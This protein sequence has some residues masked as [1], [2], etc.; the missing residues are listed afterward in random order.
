MKLTLHR[1]RTSF[2]IV[3]FLLFGQFVFGQVPPSNLSGQELKTWLKTNYWD[4]KHTALGYDNARMRLYN[5]VDN[6]NGIITCPYSG[7]QVSSPYGGTTTYPAPIN[8]EHTIPQSF[9][10]EANPMV[11]DLH[12]LF[13]THETVNGVR[14]NYPFAEIPDNVTTKWMYLSNSQTTIPTSNID[15]YSEFNGSQFEP[16]EDDKGNVARA[17]FY[18]YTMYPAQAGDMSKVGDINTFY[19]WHLSDPVDAK[20]IERNGQI[21]TYQGDRNPYIDY[22]DAVARAWGFTAPVNTAPSTPTLAIASN[23]SAITLTW[24][25]VASETG[26]KLYKSTT[27]SSFTLLT[28]LTANTIN[29]SD[30]SVVAGQNYYYYITAYNDYGTSPVSS[31]VVKQLE[32]DGGGGTGTIS[33]LIISEYIEGSSNNK[34]LEIANFTGNSV[35]LSSYTIRKQSNGAGAWGTQLALSG[36]LANGDVYVVVNASASATMKAV[37]DLST[38]VDALTFNGN[39][40]IGLFKNTT[41]IDIVGVFSAVSNFALDVTLMPG[42]RAAAGAADGH[43]VR[44]VHGFPDRTFQAAAFHRDAGRHVPGTWPVLRDQHR[45]DQHRRCFLHCGF[46]TAHSDLGRRLDLD[47]CGDRH[48]RAAG[49]GLHRALHAVRPRG[50]RGWRQ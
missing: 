26:Y 21:E 49:R 37:A 5:Y 1:K 12:H 44:R 16:R 36:T 46:A 24:S 31:T 11:S 33:D 42:A 48:R 13:P 30:A 3:L 15:L 50:L 14:S 20:E 22:P 8:C 7:Y 47:Q 41:L 25:N 18:F 4:G 23:T 39:D 43:C 38:S 27:G 32:T 9:F 40:P 29:Y 45:L 34:G 10:G 6:E 35:D 2:F 17:I 19:Q 28:T